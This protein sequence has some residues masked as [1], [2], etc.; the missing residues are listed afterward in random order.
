[1]NFPDLEEI[2]GLASADYEQEFLRAEFAP[3]LAYYLERIDRLMFAGDRV[4]D[5]GCGAGQWA[6]ALAQRFR[7]V[8]AVDLK[9]ERLAVLNAV[10]ERMGV[11]NVSARPGTLE[12][13]DYP[14]SAFDAVFSYNVLMLVAVE[15]VLRELLRVLRPGGRMY[16][17][18]NADGWSRYLAEEKGKASAHVR[19][20]GLSTL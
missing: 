15:P 6:M 11:Q 18:I 2:V 16:A 8:D 19:R 4:L 3:G 7:R 10:A 9:L 20:A 12:Q 14:D 13:L 5:A 1:M 17:C